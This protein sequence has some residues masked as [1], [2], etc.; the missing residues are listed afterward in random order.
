MLRVQLHS[1]HLL[2]RDVAG[3]AVSAAPQAAQYRGGHRAGTTAQP[4]PPP[5]DRGDTAPHRAAPP[6]VPAR[7]QA[8]CGAQRP[9]QRRPWPGGAAQGRRAGPGRWAELVA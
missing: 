7:A 5:L 9:A 3:P 8:A 4:P 2:Q 1:R 6:P